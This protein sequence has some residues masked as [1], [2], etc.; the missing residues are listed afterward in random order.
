MRFTEIVKA[1]NFGMKIDYK[2]IEIDTVF[3]KSCSSLTVSK[4]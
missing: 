1:R 4:Q 3:K 2:I